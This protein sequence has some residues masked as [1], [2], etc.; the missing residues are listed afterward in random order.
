MSEIPDEEISDNTVV[1]DETE[2]PDDETID[3]NN[4]KPEIKKNAGRSL[5]L[6]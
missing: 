6:L 2:T 4:Y 5:T 1:A 3:E